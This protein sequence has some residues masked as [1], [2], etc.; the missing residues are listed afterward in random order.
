MQL[1]LEPL[2]FSQILITFL[3]STQNFTLFGKKDHIHSL[4]ILKVI[5]FEDC[6]YLNA[7]KFFF[8]NTIR[9]STC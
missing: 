3:K 1:S 9:Q 6:G 2:R 4:I 8:Q 7:R 5:A